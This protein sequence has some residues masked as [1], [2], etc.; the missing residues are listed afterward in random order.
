[1][2][3]AATVLDDFRDV[4]DDVRDCWI[5]ADEDFVIDLDLTGA[6]FA[7]RFFFEEEFVARDDNFWGD[8]S[9]NVPGC[10]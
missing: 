2:S 10:G 3:S 7:F 1:M 9:P 8:S 5:A 6:F 4:G